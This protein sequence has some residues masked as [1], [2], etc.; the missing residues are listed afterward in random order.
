MD[1]IG[2]LSLT[3]CKFDSIWVIVDRLTNP[4]HFIHVHT[5]YRVEKYAIIYIACVLCLPGVPK[6]I[7]FD[8]GSQFVACF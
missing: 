3:A 2:G 1:F 4:A 7:I 6:T 8:Q 5:E